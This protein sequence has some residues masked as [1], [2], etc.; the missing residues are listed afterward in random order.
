MLPD[1]F[2]WNE[3]RDRL[4]LGDFTLIIL[5]PQHYPV[6]LINIMRSCLPRRLFFSTHQI[7]I[8]YSEMWVNKWEDEIR[9]H[10]RDAQSA[11]RATW[12]NPDTDSCSSRRMG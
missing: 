3:S 10:V 7:A 1:D 2:Q 12:H 8:N 4:R 6:P 9:V 11:A 5:E